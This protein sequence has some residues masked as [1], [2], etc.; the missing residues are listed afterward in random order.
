MES[1]L[2]AIDLWDVVEEDYQVTP[3]PNNPTLVQIRRHKER[4]T[5]KAKAKLSLFVGVS[6]TILT[7]IMTL[8]TP[9]EI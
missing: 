2:E 3:L 6:Q 7:R 4:K 8:K 5:K 9:K 1:Y